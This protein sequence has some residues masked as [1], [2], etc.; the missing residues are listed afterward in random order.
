L[1]TGGRSLRRPS[2]RAPQRFTPRPRPR[3]SHHT[4]DLPLTREVSLSSSTRTIPRNIHLTATGHDRPQDR[5]PPQ[6]QTIRCHCCSQN[7]AT[8]SGTTDLAC[9]SITRSSVTKDSGQA[10]RPCHSFNS[11]PHILGEAESD[12]NVFYTSFS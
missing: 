12:L 10:C 6:G 1:L 7:Q 9:H 8:G 5:R 2:A 4:R 11:S 3:H